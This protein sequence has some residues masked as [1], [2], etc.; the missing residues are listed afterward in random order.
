MTWSVPKLWKGGECWILGGGS[1]LAVQF[2]VPDEIIQKVLRKEL[3]VSA[4]SPYM[5]AIHDKHVIAVNAAF[6]LGDWIDMLFWGD[7]RWYLVNR[8]RVAEFKGLKVTS[9]PFFDKPPFNKEKVKRL[10]KN[11]QSS[12]GIS[13]DPRKIC[14]NGNSGAAAI[15]VA[16]NAGA[17]RIVLVGFDMKLSDDKK[18]HWHNEY[19]TADRD[20]KSIEKKNLPFRRHLVGFPKIAQDA[21]ARGITIINASP[22]SA[23]TCFARMSVQDVL[24]GK[25]VPEVPIVPVPNPR[26]PRPQRMHER[27]RVH[28]K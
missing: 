2:G 23:I 4:Y 17:T 19:G 20:P 10:E 24:D 14:W 11:N 26:S 21:R 25:K 22:D 1:S 3:P 9:H 16:A 18:Q 15:S 6:L 5:S 27:R 28:R 12:H 8:S 13:S 7:K